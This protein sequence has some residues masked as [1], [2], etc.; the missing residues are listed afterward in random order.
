MNGCDRI[1]HAHMAV[2]TKP[3]SY[4]VMTNFAPSATGLAADAATYGEP[5]CYC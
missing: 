2:D 3:W 4:S 1:A 5:N